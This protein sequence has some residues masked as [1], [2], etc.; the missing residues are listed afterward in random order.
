VVNQSKVRAVL[1]DSV[2]SDFMGLFNPFSFLK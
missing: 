2:L 1:K